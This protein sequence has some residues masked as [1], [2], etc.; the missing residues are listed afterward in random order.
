MCALKLFVILLLALLV[1]G[2][3]AFVFDSVKETES[4]NPN[5]PTRT[6]KIARACSFI[7]KFGM[8]LTACGI[9]GSIVPAGLGLAMAFAIPKPTK[10]QPSSWFDHSHNVASTIPFGAIVPVDWRFLL[11]GEKVKQSIS[12]FC[13]ALQ[14]KSPA[15]QDIDLKYAT[16]FVPIRLL[17]DDYE[18]ITSHIDT[19][20]PINTDFVAGV[21]SDIIGDSS[22]GGSARKFPY[23]VFNKSAIDSVLTAFN[24]FRN[25]SAAGTPIDLEKLMHQKDDLTSAGQSARLAKSFMT[26]SL[27]DYMGFPC[28]SASDV[29]SLPSASTAQNVPY[30]RPINCLPFMA[31]QA[32]CNHFFVPDFQRRS[33]SASL[34]DISKIN[35]GLQTL[36]SIV[37][38]KDAILQL[39]YTQYESDPWTCSKNGASIMR[40]N[41]ASQAFSQISDGDTPVF[42]ANTIR[43]LFA[44]DEFARKVEYFYNDVRKQIKYMFGVVVSD[45]SALSPILVDAGSSP[46]GISEVENTSLQAVQSDSGS[47]VMQ[48]RQAAGKATSVP[49]LGSKVFE[50]EEHGV[51]MTL[52]WLRPRTSYLSRLNPMF[53]EFLDN[54]SIP[55]PLFAQIGDVARSAFDV[56]F[57]PWKWIAV[58]GSGCPYDAT[59]VFG[60]NTRYVEWKYTPDIFTGDFRSNLKYWHVARD[61]DSAV[62]ASSAFNM[63]NGKYTE[64]SQPLNRIFSVIEGVDGTRPFQLQMRFNTQL[65]QPYPHIDDEL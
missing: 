10:V 1:L 27:L 51:F 47:D 44:L 24:A 35:S 21:P 8:I 3:L 15:M 36:A 4:D 11:P 28:I 32:I 54:N 34:V 41:Q 55:N 13:R 63:I 17:S 40:V 46:I 49:R 7:V 58:G 43:G 23:F 38:G 25:T 52:V 30:S 20:N 59:P 26:G 65:W 18:F 22:D 9:I 29:S 42:N 37:Q 16:Y 2:V 45:R 39:R 53:S 57:N 6:Y 56:D 31:Y 5:Y 48:T 64:D 62:A 19:P 12:G 14:L 33:D 60:Y 50:A 61:F